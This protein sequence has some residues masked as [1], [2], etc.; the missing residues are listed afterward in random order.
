M[1]RVCVY[2]SLFDNIYIYGVLY[3]YLYIIQYF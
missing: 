2:K 3:I 1:C